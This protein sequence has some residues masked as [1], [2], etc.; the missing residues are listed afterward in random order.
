MSLCEVPA[1]IY[2]YIYCCCSMY[3]RTRYRRSKAHL[4]LTLTSTSQ[5]SPWATSNVVQP[6]VNVAV[7][8][9]VVRLGTSA[10]W[11]KAFAGESPNSSSRT[12][13]CSSSTGGSSNSSPSRDGDV[14]EDRRRRRRRP[15]AGLPRDCIALH[16]RERRF[17]VTIAMCTRCLL[18]WLC[19]LRYIPKGVCLPE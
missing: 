2:C 17:S 5:V 18:P 4:C 8:S 13:C 10:N 19:R 11:S 6:Y 9:L 12:D 14:S 16:P 3:T 7:L 1:S 15:A